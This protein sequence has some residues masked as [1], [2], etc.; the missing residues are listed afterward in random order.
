MA[1]ANG[2]HLEEL[3]GLDPVAPLARL[4]HWGLIPLLALSVV[5]AQV[6][7]IH[8]DAAELRC[9]SGAIQRLYRRVPDGAVLWWQLA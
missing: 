9:V 2:W 4:D 8:C 5:P 3:F 6:M 1:L 7:A